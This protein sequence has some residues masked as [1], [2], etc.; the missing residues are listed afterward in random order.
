MYDMYP[1]DSPLARDDPL[2]PASVR[3][4][5][6]AAPLTPAAPGRPGRAGPAGQ[7]RRRRRRARG[8][9]RGQP[10]RQ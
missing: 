1:W 9:A 4:P 8:F 5:A 6:K 3:K 7:R 2:G 10:A